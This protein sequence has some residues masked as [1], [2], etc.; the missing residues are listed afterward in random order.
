M[1]G[2]LQ[3]YVNQFFNRYRSHSVD[4]SSWFVVGGFSLWLLLGVLLYKSYGFSW[5]EV[6]EHTTGAVSLNFLLDRLHFTSAINDPV[7]L[8]FRHLHLSTYP[9]RIFGSIWGIV[10]LILER[11]FNIGNGTDERAIYQFRHLLNFLVCFI[12]AISIYQLS[13][14]RFSSWKIGLLTTTFF[15]LSPRFFAESFYNSKDL[16]F[17]SIFA[18]ACNQMIAFILRP[19]FRTATY[20]ALSVALAIDIRITGIIIIAITIF[21][22]FIQLPSAKVSKTRLLSVFAIYLFISTASVVLFWP[23]LWSNPGSHFIEALSAFS[24]WVR[25]DMSLLFFGH[26]IRSTQLPWY[27]ALAWI[28]ITTPILYLGLFLVGASLTIKQM[29]YQHFHLW[30]NPEEM[31]DWIFMGI[32]FFPLVAVIFFQS[33]LYDGWRHLYFIYPAFLLIATKGAI[34]IWQSAKPSKPYR[35]LCVVILVCSLFLTFSWM[36]RAHPLQNVYFNILAGSNWKDRFDVDYWGLSNRQGLEYI[37]KNDQRSLIKVIAGSNLA[38]DGALRILKPADR[39]R[40]IDIEWMGDADYIITNYRNNK[41]DY[42]AGDSQFSLLKEFKVDSETIASVYK[43]NIN[44]TSIERPILNQRIN[45]SS[46]GIGKYF[47]VGIGATPQLGW[48]WGFPEPWG[49]WSDG[50][51]AKLDL[52]LPS[53]SPKTLALELIP[54]INTKHPRQVLEVWINGQKNKS[55]TLQNPAAE[56][57]LIDLTSLP[58]MNTPLQIEFKTPEAISPQNLGLGDDVRKLG[59]GLISATF[60]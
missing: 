24:R 13:Q 12:G 46:T 19:S 54:F 14:R 42:A 11:L 27:Y 37:A 16:I 21:T 50:A 3:K 2:L 55:I 44:F 36:V 52:L 17:L 5:D 57:L 40:I 22:F 1:L 25:N 41:I 9:D 26:T 33:V 53:P 32:F 18:I 8:Q 59:I 60:Y 7:L 20:A 58:K 35:L 15:I 43:R 51:G 39:A 28:T 30:R 10:T 56:I 38:L 47:L 23:W 49:V 6:T 34:F 4:S 48:G 29:L 31:Q 45:F